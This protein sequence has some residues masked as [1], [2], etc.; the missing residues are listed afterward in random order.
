MV[1]K[2]SVMEVDVAPTNLWVYSEG[3]TLSV[4]LVVMLLNDMDNEIERLDK[5]LL[6]ISKTI[7]Y[8]IDRE[9][10][11]G[12]EYTAEIL[13]DIKERFNL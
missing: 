6:E 9:R 2:Y 11:N 8:M 12:D 7:N 5:L 13:N 4:P 1:E 10:S 3:A